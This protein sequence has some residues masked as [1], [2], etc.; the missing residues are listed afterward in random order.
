MNGLFEAIRR[1]PD[2]AALIVLCLTLGM[3]GQ[4]ARTGRLPV[5]HETTTA[6]YRVWTGPACD[7]LDNLH[8]HLRDLGP[9]RLLNY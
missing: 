5:C 1:N 9:Q 7:F 6:I 4:A 3:G 2:A 8:D